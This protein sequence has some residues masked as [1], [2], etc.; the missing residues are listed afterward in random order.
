[1]EK[2][3]RGSWI[4]SSLLAA[5][6]GLA[7]VS[8]S[9]LACAP[10]PLNIGFIG[11]MTGPTANIGVEGYRGFSLA[12]AEINDGGG[13]LGRKLKPL[14]LD[15]AADPALCL[16]AARELVSRGIKL[17]VL[18]TTSGAAAGAL[19]FLLEQD[20]LAL[21]RTVSD[22]A[23]V[24]L[25]DGFLRFVGSTELFGSTLGAFARGMGKQG[26]AVIIDQ[27]NSSYA[28]SMT[29]GLLAAAPELTLLGE[30]RVGQAMPHDELAAWVL[31][32]GSDAVFAVLAGLD[33]AK[34]AQAL[35]REGFAGSLF[36][37]PWSQD[38]NL[39]A[40]AGKLAPRIFLP[41]S[42]NPDDVN[43]RY[44]VFK[45]KHTELYG[46]APVMSGVFGYEI[47]RFLAQ[48]IH[49]ARS[50]APERVK[51]ALLAIGSFDGLQ[52]GFS[53]DGMGDSSM[54]ALVITIKNGAYAPAEPKQ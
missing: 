8:V 13:P 52:Y 7:L 42:F 6:A 12:I 3:G 10:A 31:G 27:R 19:P 44:L 39:L 51:A 26:L 37:S 5:I 25:D 9:L 15:D 1:M 41:S 23:W 28:D 24:G 33:A 11:P 47:G 54:E 16:A 45:E 21:T 2:N 35:E 50:P 43:P 20:A 30:R 4:A 34:L 22:P 14:M 32:L 53:L 48:G 49:R 38:Q 36:L 46:E 17:I 29:Q 40:Y 18:H